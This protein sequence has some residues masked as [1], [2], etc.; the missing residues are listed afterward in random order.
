MISSEGYA[1]APRLSRDGKHAFYLF[2]RDLVADPA[3]WVP[4]SAELRSVD[5]GSGK[6]ETLLPGV[7]VGDYDI[8]QD[9][10][11][12]A[13]TVTENGES[14]IWLAALDRSTPPREIATGD[15]VSFG[16]EGSSS[17]GPWREQ[18]ILWCGSRRTA[19]D[20]NH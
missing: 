15:Q 7:A 16:A 17:S 20:E 11:E 6:T 10:K 4:S 5:L 12:A 19:V 14:K 2:A 3:N 8:S 1:V 13:F 18:R 9:E